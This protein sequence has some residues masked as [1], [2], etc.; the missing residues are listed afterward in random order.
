MAHDVAADGR[1]TC[2]HCNA[3]AL[4]Q[5]N[6][7]QVAVL[8][9]RHT[10]RSAACNRHEAMRLQEGGGAAALAYPTCARNTEAARRCVAG[11]GVAAG[12]PRA[13]P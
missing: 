13:H 10:L 11:D 5:G 6:C 12:A 8:L 2:T 7:R 4:R 1:I 9:L 3:D